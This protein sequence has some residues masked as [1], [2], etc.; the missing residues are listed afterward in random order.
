M[1]NGINNI[2]NLSILPELLIAQLHNDNVIY[3]KDLREI[4]KKLNYS[5]AKKTLSA[6]HKE[7]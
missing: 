5:L 4:L 6:Y 3:R 7:I 1:M 2:V